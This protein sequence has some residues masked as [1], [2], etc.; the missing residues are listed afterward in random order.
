MTI[1]EWINQGSWYGKTSKEPSVPTMERTS[2]LFL[3]KQPKS[4]IKMPQFLDLRT[5]NGNH[6][7]SSWEMGIPSLGEDM[8]PNT[9]EFL[10]EESVFVYWLTSKEMQ[11]QGYCLKVNFGEHPIRENPTK[12]SQIL[13]QNPDNKYNLS[14]RACQGILNRAER[15]GKTLPPILKEALERQSVFKNEQESQGGAKEY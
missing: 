9:G 11:L 3:K 8:M 4:K 6:A 10:R 14:A 13:E 1:E 2:E 5:G 15:R 12:L 7:E